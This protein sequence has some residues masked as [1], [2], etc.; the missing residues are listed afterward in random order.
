[1]VKVGDFFTLRVKQKTVAGYANR[2]R[3]FFWNVGLAR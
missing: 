3:R 1:V 2:S